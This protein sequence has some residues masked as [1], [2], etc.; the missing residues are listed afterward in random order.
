MDNEMNVFGPVIL[1][2]SGSDIP[3]NPKDSDDSDTEIS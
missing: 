3:V 1:E 2:S